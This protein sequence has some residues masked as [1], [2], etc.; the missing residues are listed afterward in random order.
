MT[1]I[2]DDVSQT[3]GMLKTWACSSN[4]SDGVATSDDGDSEIH[5]ARFLPRWVYSGLDAADMRFDADTTGSLGT[6]NSSGSINWVYAGEDTYT[7]AGAFHAMTVAG[8][9]TLLALS[10]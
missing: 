2:S 4:Y 10:F 1:T 6:Q 7:W 9:A 8:A 5:C 3:Q